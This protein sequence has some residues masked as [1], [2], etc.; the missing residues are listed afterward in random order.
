MITDSKS[1]T[2]TEINFRNLVFTHE[3]CDG[4]ELGGRKCVCLSH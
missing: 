4:D 1:D 2:R 3:C